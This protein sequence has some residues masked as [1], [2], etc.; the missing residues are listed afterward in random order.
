MRGRIESGR[1]CTVAPVDVAALTVGDVVL[2]TVRGQ[3]YLHLIKAVRG[4]E[5]QIGNNVGR[6][7][8]WVDASAIH[9]RCVSVEA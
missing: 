4:S 3:Q 9:G 8:G 2:C 1:R 6:I 7:N 5:F